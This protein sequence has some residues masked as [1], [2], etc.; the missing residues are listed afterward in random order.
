MPV[1]SWYAAFAF[2]RRVSMSAIGS[3]IVM[4]LWPSSPWFPVRP[5]RP[6]GT[7]GVVG[8]RCAPASIL[9]GTS[10]RHPYLIGY[11]WLPARLGDAGQ[12]ATVRHIAEAHPAN[13]EP[14]VYGAR[15]PAARASRI[16][17]HLELR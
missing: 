11:G 12:L 4:A 5:S 15:P 2:R 9:A 1:V 16:G 17:P 3:V 8:G 14:P 10:A 7:S 6:S 13:A